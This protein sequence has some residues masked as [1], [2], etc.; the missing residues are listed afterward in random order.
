MT[1]LGGRFGCGH[2]VVRN[3]ALSGSGVGADQEIQP[4]KHPPH[5]IWERRGRDGGR[6]SAHLT[7]PVPNNNTDGVT[8]ITLDDASRT[9]ATV[10]GGA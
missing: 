5:S 3:S 9:P 7:E 8:I 4:A 10:P 6:G 2:L 1:V